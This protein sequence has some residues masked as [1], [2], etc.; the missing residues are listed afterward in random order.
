MERFVCL[1]DCPID[2]VRSFPFVPLTLAYIDGLL[3][4]CPPGY[5][6]LEWNESDDEEG[7][8]DDEDG[9]SSSGDDEDE[10]EGGPQEGVE[11]PEEEEEGEAEGDEA[12]GKVDKR[13]QAEK[14]R[15]R[16]HSCAR[17]P[18]STED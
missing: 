17:K 3:F 5:L 7:G 2:A 4:F 11:A 16:F 1:K 6:Q 15:D 12:E 13:T 18:S 9:S 10:E 14:V 8:S